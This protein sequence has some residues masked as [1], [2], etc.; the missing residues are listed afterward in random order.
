MICNDNGSRGTEFTVLCY[1][2]SIGPFN[3][4]GHPSITSNN[5]IKSKRNKTTRSKIDESLYLSQDGYSALMYSSW[6]GGE[7]AVR[8]L[9]EAKADANTL[10]NVSTH[11]RIGNIE[12]ALLIFNVSKISTFCTVVEIIEASVNSDV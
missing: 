7:G 6:R 10:N 4:T 1:A 9:L 11:T 3:H 12:S 2:L 5:Y 8:L